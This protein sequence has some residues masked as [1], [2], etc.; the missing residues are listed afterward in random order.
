MYTRIIRPLGY[1]RVYLPLHKVADTPF[2][3]Q[4]DDY[5][6]HRLVICTINKNPAVLNIIENNFFALD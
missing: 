1:E 3:I 4:G 2:H 6:A 5:I